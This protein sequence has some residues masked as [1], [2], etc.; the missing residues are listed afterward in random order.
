MEKI[1]INISADGLQI[2]VDLIGYNLNFEGSLSIQQKLVLSIITELS[3]KLEK[4]LIDKRNIKKK[5]RISLKYYEAYALHWL[6]ASVAPFK[7]DAYT[8]N[9][10]TLVSNEIHKQ[11]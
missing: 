7:L 3:Q 2:L 8:A 9:V 6:C 11:L 5:F 10:L 1:K 4:K